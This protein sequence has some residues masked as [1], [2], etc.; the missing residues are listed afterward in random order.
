MST[1]LRQINDR[2]SCK[3]SL[4]ELFAHKQEIEVSMGVKVSGLNS[5][6]HQLNKL[7]D[8][9]SMAAALKGAVHEGA[10]VMRSAIEE[11]TPERTDKWTEGTR[12]T[13]LPPGR[14]REGLFIDEYQG[15]RGNPVAVIRFDGE[16]ERVARWVNFGHRIVRDGKSKV[17][18]NGKTRG[19]GKVVGFAAPTY[20]FTE[21]V[22]ETQGQV[23]D[24][25]RSRLQE[26]LAKLLKS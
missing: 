24:I 15:Q 17:L 11:H 2:F 25:V 19:A 23:A 7:S 10:E 8:P 6:L 14:L 12:S 20:F 26:S 4:S 16:A 21:T 3:Q 5:I 1:L 22:E 9:N 13:A 18:K